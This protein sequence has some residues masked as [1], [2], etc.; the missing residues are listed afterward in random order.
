MVVSDKISDFW[1][2][3]IFYLITRGGT[4]EVVFKSWIE[5]IYFVSFRLW[6][7]IW[8]IVKY[9]SVWLKKYALFYNQLWP[10]N[11][12]DQFFKQDFFLQKVK[13]LLSLKIYKLVA[14]TLGTLLMD[15]ATQKTLLQSRN[16]P[17]KN[18]CEKRRWWCTNVWQWDGFGDG[19]LK[20]FQAKPSLCV[21]GSRNVL[22]QR[23]QK[24][25]HCLRAH[26]GLH[27]SCSPHILSDKQC[28]RLKFP[29]SLKIST[30]PLAQPLVFQLP[31]GYGWKC[32]PQ[33]RTLI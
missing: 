9:K 17:F 12:F 8:Q 5:T 19:S 1:F 24:R 23:V 14:L 22:M 27:S 2:D 25:K 28:T 16:P 20:T 4:T 15:I 32:N 6:S 10:E 13:V 31:W 33:K 11:L 18:D 3:R 29:W 26:N 30:I 21:M 7:F